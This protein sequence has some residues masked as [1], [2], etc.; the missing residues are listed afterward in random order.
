[1]DCN[2]TEKHHKPE[3]GNILFTKSTLGSKF[4]D[5]AFFSEMWEPTRFNE[6]RKRCIENRS[7]MAASTNAWIHTNKSFMG[8]LDDVQYLQQIVSQF[9]NRTAPRNPLPMFR[10]P[11]I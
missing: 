6:S 3:M 10:A 9:E 4:V 7:D 2:K 1:M 11:L 8:G 5:A